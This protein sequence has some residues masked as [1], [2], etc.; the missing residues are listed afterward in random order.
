M[1]LARGERAALYALVHLRLWLCFFKGVLSLFLSASPLRVSRG[2]SSPSGVQHRAHT[3]WG[4]A[5]HPGLTVRITCAMSRSTPSKNDTKCLSTSF[6][7][8]LQAPT[9]LLCR[10]DMGGSTMAGSSR[11]PNSAMADTRVISCACK[12][13][14][15]PV[16]DV[17]VW[18]APT[19]HGFLTA[20]PCNPSVNR[21]SPQAFCA[22]PEQPPLQTR[23]LPALLAPR[24]KRARARAL[25]N[26]DSQLSTGSQ[27]GVWRTS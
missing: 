10:A 20:N 11:G 18:T 14:H 13:F 6:L 19:M 7:C 25:P 2:I 17:V 16:R 22:R 5:Q 9:A 15:T 12:K 4:C 24:R 21:H 27:H 23:P 3:L 26:R 1:R 8:E